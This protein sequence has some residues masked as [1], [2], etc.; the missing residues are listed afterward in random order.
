[1]RWFNRKV[2]LVF[3][4]VLIAATPLMLRAGCRQSS[5]PMASTEKALYQCSMHPSV[6][7]SKPGNCP[8]CGMRLNRVRHERKILY[9]RHPMRPD[10]TSPRPAKDEMG[11]DYI[12]VYEEGETSS[13]GMQIPGHAEVVLSPERQ[14]L[15]GV[16]MAMVEERPLVMT[17]RTVGRVAYDPE[18]YNALSEYRE[19]VAVREKMKNSPLPEMR[20]RAEALVRSVELKLK[21]LGFSDP[22]LAE[23]LKP[24]AQS[25]NLLLSSETAWIYA[26]IYEYE[27]GSVK[28]GQIAD[29]TT[30]ALPGVFLKGTVKSVDAVFNTATRTLRARI[31]LP[32]P[33]KTLKPEMFV[34][35]MIEVP[36]GRKL[37]IPKE[38][39]FQAGETQLVFV[40]KGEGHFEPRQI[41]VGHEAGGY[42]EI[43]SGLSAGEK[44]VRSANFLID[45]ESRFQA[46]ARGF[47]G[48]EQP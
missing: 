43:L 31:E 6:V 34:D 1:M 28:P 30:A 3:V 35:V 38:A 16:Q 24:G 33:D 11:M 48:D 21:L 2:F 8:I 25:G 19:A 17:I 42:Y 22:Q 39:L 10:V 15:I 36:L 29:V 37:A 7:S 32:N 47:K 20:E 18:L 44:V 23:L 27:S 5:A 12:P 41:Q 14:Q 4:A 9:Y 13:G 26:D 40:D 45:S 46:A